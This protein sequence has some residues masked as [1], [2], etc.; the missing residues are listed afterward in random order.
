MADTG[1]RVTPI[2]H[3]DKKS[4]VT[5]HSSGTDNLSVEVKRMAIFVLASS[6]FLI[7]IG[8]GLAITIF[9]AISFARER[10]PQV[11]PI[12]DLSDRS[13]SRAT[14]ACR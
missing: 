2:R 11:N 13:A 3:I 8:V 10:E 5:N 4:V 7:S 6:G 1:T 12:L 9:C 14:H